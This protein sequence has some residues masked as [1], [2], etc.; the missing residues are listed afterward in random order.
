MTYYPTVA[1]S[2]TLPPAEEL[3][4]ALIS[5]PCD[6]LYIREFERGTRLETGDILNIATDEGN[7]EWRIV[8]IDTMPDDTGYDQYDYCLLDIA[9]EQHIALTN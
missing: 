9:C 1:T 7:E 8:Q 3:F 4:R 2:L 5:G 6:P